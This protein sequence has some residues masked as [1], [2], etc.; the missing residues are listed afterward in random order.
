MNR[1]ILSQLRAL[2]RY[3]SVR[4]SVL[5]GLLA[6]WIMSDPSILPRLVHVVPPE[7]RPFVALAVGFATYALPT[8]ARALPQTK[9]GADD[10]S[11][12]E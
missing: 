2:H 4:L 9:L 7:W 11:T 5:A 1:Q 8:A 6:G 3:W 10:W 12:V